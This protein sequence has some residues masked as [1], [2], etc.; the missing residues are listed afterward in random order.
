VKFDTVPPGSTSVSNECQNFLPDPF[1][2]DFFR[3]EISG[4]H[5]F[6]RAG[7]LSQGNIQV[8]R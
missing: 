1:P 8:H 2:L 5:A 6:S 7:N 3:I 4:S